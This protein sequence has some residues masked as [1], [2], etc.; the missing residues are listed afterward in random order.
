MV[1]TQGLLAIA[2]QIVDR[3]GVKLLRDPYTGK[4]YV[5]FMPLKE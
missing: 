2:Y 4:P 5:K 1:L 3:P